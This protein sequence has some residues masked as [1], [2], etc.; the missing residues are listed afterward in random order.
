M[1]E[2]Q[3]RFQESH[4]LLSPCKCKKKCSENITQ[5]TRDSIKQLWKLDYNCRKL[6]IESCIK[7]RFS[8]RPRKN[9]SGAY[10]HNLTREYF[11]DDH[12][13][14]G[15]NV[16]KVFFVSTLGYKSYNIITYTLITTR[17]EDIAPPREKRGRRTPPNKIL[18][19]SVLAHIKSFSPVI[20]HY[21]RE[22]TPNHLY[23]T[24]EITI[25]EMHRDFISKLPSEKVSYKYYRKKVSKMNISFSKL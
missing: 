14:N 13:N 6:R 18:S 19:S 15:H 8:K 25:T 5:K 23:L 17:A 22:H 21:W 16:C 4:S 11:L 9:T 1:T 7:L 24:A 3:F 20:S 2:K 12:G 10:D